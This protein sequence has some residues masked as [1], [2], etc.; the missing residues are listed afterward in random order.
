MGTTRPLCTGTCEWRGTAGHEKAGKLRRAHKT[1][2]IMIPLSAL[3][4]FTGNVTTSSSTAAQ[5]FVW[6]DAGIA[7]VQ[8]ACRA[9]ACVWCA[10]HANVAMC[11]MQT[12]GKSR[13]A[14][15]AWLLLSRA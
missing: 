2:A 14:T 11:V 1:M 10:D 9:H 4:C 3:S 6:K 13:L 7:K 12:Q 5:V 15:L 8:N